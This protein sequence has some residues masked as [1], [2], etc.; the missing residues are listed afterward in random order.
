MSGAAKLAIYNFGLFVAPYESPEVDG[1]RLREPANF[2][3]AERSHGFL[4]RSGYPGEGGPESWGPQIFPH[5]IAGSG[6]EWA[7]S[8]L[9]LWADLESLMAFT[10]N[11]VHADA[12]KHAHG[13]QQK[14]QWPALALWWTEIRPDWAEAVGRFEYLYEH[15]PSFEAFNFKEPYGPDGGKTTI[16]RARVRELATL[17]AERQKDLLAHVLSVGV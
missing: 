15:G 9:S 17:N 16:D 8:S 10:Y 6:F 3:A 12:L 11:G 1:F 13:W 7:P 14:R 2:L 5:F 4:G